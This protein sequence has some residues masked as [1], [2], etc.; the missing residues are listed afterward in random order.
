MLRPEERHQRLRR[1]RAKLQYHT[2]AFRR[3]I[4]GLNRKDRDQEGDFVS[5][6]PW[7]L[8]RQLD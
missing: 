1:R 2:A 3:D 4:A 5:I 7:H 6:T 8:T